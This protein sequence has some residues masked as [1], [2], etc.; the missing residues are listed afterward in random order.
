MD[1]F[2]TDDTAV[3]PVIGVILMVAI[4]VLLASTAAVF[5][6]EFGNGAGSSTQPTVAFGTDYSQGDASTSDEVTFSH[7]SGDNLDTAELQLVVKDAKSQ[8]G[9]SISAANGRHDVQ[10]LV[11]QSEWSAGDSIDISSNT[12]SGVSDPADFS[13]AT[14]KLVWRGS[15]QSTILAEWTGPDA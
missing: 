10:S 7:Q 2:Q 5:F 13:E 15:G 11:S 1:E 12:W 4:T 6:L 9:N 3:S 8:S 14:I